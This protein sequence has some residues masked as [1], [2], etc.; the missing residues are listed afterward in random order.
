[1]SLQIT[2]H[3]T[4]AEVEHSHEAIRRGIDNSLP[5]DLRANAQ[6][7]ASLCLEPL[8][9]YLKTPISPTSWYRCP[10]LDAAIRGDETLSKH[11][12]HLSLIH[13]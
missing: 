8:R 1:M 3:F 2:E 5:D 10:E 11:T 4:D 12:Q 7:V 9:A 6:R 13:I